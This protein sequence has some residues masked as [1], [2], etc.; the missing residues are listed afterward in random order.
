MLRKF[1]VSG[2]GTHLYRIQISNILLLLDLTEQYPQLPRRLFFNIGAQLG[3]P[4][5]GTD[6]RVDTKPLFGSR[7]TEDFILVFV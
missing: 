1:V 7:T 4:T 5:L 2:D 6:E 3:Q